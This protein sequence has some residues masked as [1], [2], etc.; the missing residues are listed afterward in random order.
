MRIT[1]EDG[2]FCMYL[3]E[4]ESG[5]TRLVEQGTDFLGAARTFGWAGND[6]RQFV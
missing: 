4:A 3:I 5:E 2:P 1:L 6:R